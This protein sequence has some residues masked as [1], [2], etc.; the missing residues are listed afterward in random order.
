MS[1]LAVSLDHHLPDI[2]LRVR[3]VDHRDLPA[4]EVMWAGCS[5]ETR[6]RRFLG[7][8]GEARWLLGLGPGPDLPRVD[9]GAWEG[10][11]LVGVASL[12]G[13]GAGAWEPAMIVEDDRQGR[14]VGGR[15]ADSLLR[16]ATAYGVRELELTTSADSEAVLRL[17]RRRAAS[18]S[19]VW[20]GSGIAEYRAV[21]LTPLAIAAPG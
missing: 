12:V 15:L 17:L 10:E 6:A 19:L 3:P 7:G 16:A 9:L 18:W 14:G 11:R 21:P 13:D 2:P 4:V 1:T 5:E 20:R 8:R